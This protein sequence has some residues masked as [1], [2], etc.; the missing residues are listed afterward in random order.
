MS[1]DFFP[2]QPMIN[3]QRFDLRPLRV[4]DT[5]QI[6][7]HSADLRIARMTSRIAHPLPPGATAAFI[8]R[9]MGKTRDEDIWAIDDSKSAR[10]DL[11]GVISLKRLDRDQ[12]QSSY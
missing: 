4:S 2:D 8:E 10:P 5:G 9:A 1:L 6:T 3:A 11:M 12:S 7:L